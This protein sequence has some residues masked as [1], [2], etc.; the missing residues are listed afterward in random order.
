M[1]LKLI[2]FEFTGHGGVFCFDVICMGMVVG[3]ASGRAAV[4]AL[5]LALALPLVLV[6][7]HN[8][9]GGVGPVAVIGCGCR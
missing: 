4:L 3:G 2:E 7:L 8:S 1:K 6:N 9:G 5:P